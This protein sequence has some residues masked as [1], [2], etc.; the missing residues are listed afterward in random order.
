M[1]KFDIFII[2]SV[3][4]RVFNFFPV[5]REENFSF[6]YTP[7]IERYLALPEFISNLLTVR[8]VPPCFPSRI[9]TN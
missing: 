4:D 5:K 6:G 8:F 9:L 2:P 1:I 7:R 3:A